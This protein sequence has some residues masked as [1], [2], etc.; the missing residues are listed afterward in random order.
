MGANVPRVDEKRIAE[1]IDGGERSPKR[2]KTYPE[3]AMAAWARH[4]SQVGK[5][6]LQTDLAQ[7]MAKIIGQTALV[8][9]A[10]GG[11]VPG[12]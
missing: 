6:V 9:A 8:L 10:S 7:R 3:I 1:V 2:D 5:D 11:G 4:E 12:T